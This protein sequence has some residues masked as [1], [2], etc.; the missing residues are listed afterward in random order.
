MTTSGPPPRASSRLRL[1]ARIVQ[2]LAISLALLL[3]AAGEPLWWTAWTWAGLTLGAI[4]VQQILLHRNRPRLAALRQKVG[5]GTTSWD[6][7][8]LRLGRPLTIATLV[9]AGLDAGRFGWAPLPGWAWAPGVL[10]F[11]AGHTL[12]ITSMLANRH[13]ES[14]ARIQHDRG[15]RVVERGPYAYVRHPGYSGALLIVLSGPL[16]LLSGWAAV[17]AAA[18]LTLVVVRTGLEDTLL[19]RELL[20]YEQYASRVRARLIPGVW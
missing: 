19:R 17:P 12:L 8:L 4:V 20:G 9:V 5:A 3:V 1:A 7:W 18:S 13:F 11:A 2:G 14:T 16:L 15:H 6:R 10:L